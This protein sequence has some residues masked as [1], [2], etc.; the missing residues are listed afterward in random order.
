M[1]RLESFQTFVKFFVGLCFLQRILPFRD[2]KVREKI[3]AGIIYTVQIRRN[4]S[5]NI[6]QVTNCIFDF[7]HARIPRCPR[8]QLELIAKR[9]RRNQHIISDKCEEFRYNGCH[10]FRILNHRKVNTCLLHMQSS[11]NVMFTSFSSIRNPFP[12]F[13]KTPP[14]ILKFLNCI[15]TRKLPNVYCKSI[16]KQIFCFFHGPLWEMQLPAFSMDNCK[17]YWLT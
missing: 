16:F 5:S 6:Q 7:A 4:I 9:V 10:C 11:K 12:P 1:L 13:R 3:L 2:C 17:Y 15:I 8:K 14:L